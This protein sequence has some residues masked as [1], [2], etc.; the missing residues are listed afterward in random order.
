[1]VSASPMMKPLRTGS[2]MKLAQESEAQQPGDHG[3]DPGREGQRHGELD[4]L[5]AALGGELGD[6]RRRQGRRGRHRS[7]HQVP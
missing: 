1:M 3:D 5:V 7:G 6:R 2:E 4:E